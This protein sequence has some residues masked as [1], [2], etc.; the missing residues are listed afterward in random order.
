MAGPLFVG[1]SV[2]QGLL[3]PGFSFTQHPPSALALGAA[4]W[5]QTVTFVV[6]GC[7]FV[8]GAW[9][10]R[11]VMTGPG[12]RWAPRLIAVFGAALVAGGVF[13]MD[14]AFGFPPG[15]PPGA[16]DSVSWHAA[17][18]GVLFPL[19]FAALVAVA[20][21]MAHRF[22]RQGRRGWQWSGIGTGPLALALCLWPNLAARPDGRFLPMW[23]GVAAAF[24]WTSA[25]IAD[26]RRQVMPTRP[27]VTDAHPRR[28]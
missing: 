8:R 7:L 9:G 21:V 10:L 4:G 11:R 26:A 25:V 22:R 17:V 6:A 28:I 23:F 19:G 15:T 14:P 5:V 3:R 12:A 16:G 18:H 27:A 1:S 13:R 20:F 2:V 24:L